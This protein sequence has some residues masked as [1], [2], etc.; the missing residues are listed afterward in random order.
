MNRFMKVKGRGESRM[1]VR[2]LH[3]QPKRRELTLSSYLDWRKLRPAGALT[4]TLKVSGGRGGQGRGETSLFQNRNRDGS[5]KNPSFCFLIPPQ[6]GWKSHLTPR[7]PQ[8]FPWEISAKC[9][10]F[11]DTKENPSTTGFPT[12]NGHLPVLRTD[13][14]AGLSCVLRKGM[15]QT[16]CIQS[17]LY[18]VLSENM[19]GG[20]LRDLSEPQFP[21][22]C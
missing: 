12:K 2:G 15:N 11:R 10:T 5:W 19:A 17:W 14:T 4:C 21:H 9:L 7:Q 1:L 3:Q 20:L 6:A 18:H 22:L 8:W 16:V 13:Q